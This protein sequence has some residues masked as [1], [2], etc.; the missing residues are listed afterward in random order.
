[1]DGFAGSGVVCR[2]AVAG[3]CDIAENC[4]GSA[5]ACPGDSVVAAGTICRASGGACDPQEV[6]NGSNSC[7]ANVLTAAGTVC[8][9]SAGPCDPQEVCTGGAACPGNTL[10]AAGTTCRSAAGI[11]DVSEACTG[12]SAACPGDSF[13]GAG[14]VCR[15]SIN[16]PYCDPAE[17]CTGSG[18]LC[19]GNTVIRSPTTEVCDAVD[20]NC[21]GTVDEGSATTCGS[22][23]NLGTLNVGGTLTRT[24]Y[25]PAPVGSEQWYVVSVPQNADFAQHG[26]GT[27]QI[28]LTSGG[29]V[30]FEVQS[31]CGANMPCG[32]G[33][34]ATGLTHWAFSDTASAAGAGAYTS[35]AVAWPTTMYIRVYR[36]SATST[37][38]NQTLTISRP[39]GSAYQAGF[40]AGV[41]PVGTLS[42]SRWDAFR[43]SLDPARTYTSITMSGSNNTTG[44]TCT[45][46]AANSICQA[47]RTGSSFS[48]SCGGNTWTV[49]QCYAGRIELNADGLFCNCS[50]QWSMRPCHEDPNFG[51][52]GGPSSCGQAYQTLQANCQ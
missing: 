6:C 18:A 9:A 20:N 7:P 50:S 24:E 46:A 11:C 8:R 45:G 33:G 17:V 1:G 25:I 48:V 22:A 5:A 16:Q 27:P 36:V 29:A 2:A 3:G 13:V 4:T 51:G 10:T 38:A 30:R 31:S 40:T 35:R 34:S 32:S 28:T 37:C 26:T 23:I 21:N 43:A 12:S 14:T 19:P 44:R 47:L 42:C 39:A 52:V 15:P 41:A 49:G